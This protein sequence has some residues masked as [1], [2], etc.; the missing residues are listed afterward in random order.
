MKPSIATRSSRCSRSY[1]RLKSV[2]WSGSIS[3]DV[4]NM[5]FPAIGIFQSLHALSS[6]LRGTNAKRLRKGAL[7]TKIQC[8]KQFWIASLALAMTVS[9][10][11]LRRSI[12]DRFHHGIADA[13]IIQR[14]AGALHD[15][16]LGIWPPGCKRVRGRG[17]AQQIEAPLHDEAGN[18]LEFL[19]VIQKLVGLH[20]AI[21]GEVMRFHEGRGGQGA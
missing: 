17:W 20:E 8:P 9:A 4:S 19:H 12:R 16:K 10:L 3:I 6:S 2:S 21:V 13:W 7:A 5:P 14:M 11:D 1:Q 15:A 18:A